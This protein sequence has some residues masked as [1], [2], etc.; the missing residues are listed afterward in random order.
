MSAGG[1]ERMV[2]PGRVGANPPSSP[3]LP[4]PPP[5]P[6]PFL[7]FPD[8]GTGRAHVVEEEG[9]KKSS[10]SAS[11]FPS[12]FPLAVR[13]PATG[14]HGLQ[15]GRHSASLFFSF[16]FVDHGFNLLESARVSAIGDP[17]L[18]CESTLS[19]PLPFFPSSFPV[20]DA[21][22]SGGWRGLS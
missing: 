22:A 10:G 5:P 14:A 17:T 6:L 8:R 13:K 12:F 1:S 9:E 16:S 20:F 19:P 21:H 4:A 7:P 3:L 2:P 11:F 15:E 18:S